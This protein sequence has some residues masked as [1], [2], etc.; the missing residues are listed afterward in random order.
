[1]YFKNTEKNLTHA[2]VGH[3]RPFLQ[4]LNTQ[5]CSSI[6]NV[7]IFTV[8]DLKHGWTSDFKHRH[9]LMKKYSV[10]VTGS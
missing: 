9:G 2:H 1:M 8:Q 10:I 6:Q 5:H 3:D 7:H 4:N